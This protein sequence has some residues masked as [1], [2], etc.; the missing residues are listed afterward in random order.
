MRRRVVHAVVVAHVVRR[1]VVHAVVVAHVVRGRVVAARQRAE[2][3]VVVAGL[4]PHHA[5][6]GA[7]AAAHEVGEVHHASAA[8]QRRPEGHRVRAQ[9]ELE[10]EAAVVAHA[11]DDLQALRAG[12]DDLGAA[13]AAGP[14]GELTLDG[15]ALGAAAGGEPEE[16]GEGDDSLEVHCVALSKLTMAP[17]TGLEQPTEYA[18]RIR[19]GFMPSI[20]SVIATT[21]PAGSTAMHTSQNTPAG[22]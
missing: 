10:R 11:A 4:H 17:A 3:D 8:L 21:Q 16:G 7:A 5:A 1:R 14:R 20:F 2:V 6:R 9:R 12:G 22:A 15:A 18:S 19:R 13:G